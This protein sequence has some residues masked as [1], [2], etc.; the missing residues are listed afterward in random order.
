MA[1]TS[2]PQCPRHSREGGNPVGVLPLNKVCNRRRNLSIL[3]PGL[4]VNRVLYLS[5]LSTL[6]RPAQ[7]HG[8][9]PATIEQGAH[10]FEKLV[11]GPIDHIYGWA[12]SYK[13]CLW[14]LRIRR[15]CNQRTHSRRDR[16]RGG[17]QW[18]GRGV[19]GHCAICCASPSNFLVLATRDFNRWD[20]ERQR[21]IPRRHC[22][23]QHRRGVA[24]FSRVWYLSPPAIHTTL[25]HRTMPDYDLSRLSPRA[26]EHL[27]QA[28]AVKVLGPG[29]VVFGDGPDGGREATFE[30]SVPYPTPDNPWNGYGVV[31]AKYHERSGDVQQDGK[32]A[33][34]Q[35]KKELRKYTDPDSQLRK[36]EYLIY[37]TNVV[38]TPARRRG[39]KDRVTA[40]LDDF[41]K[42]T[43]LRDYAVWDYDQLR[44][45]LDAYE[46][47][48]H[49]YA[50]YITSG[51][52]LAALI[53][54]LGPE[55]MGLYNTL[56][57]FL[58]K[59]LLSDECV[60]LAQAGHDTEDRI[61]L[62]TVFVDLPMQIDPT[63]LDEPFW[64][65][66]DSDDDNEIADCE[67]YTEGF[68]KHILTVASERL[69]PIS[70]G[71]SAISHSFDWTNFRE[72]RGRFVLIGGPGQGKT[73]LTQFLCQIFR[74][75]IISG[76]SSDTISLEVQEALDIIRK[77]CEME[78]INPVVVPRFPFKVVLNDFAKAL[79]SDLDPAVNSLFTYLARQ[80]STR[81]GNGVSASALRRFL[82]IYPSLV[83]FDGLDEVPASSNRDEVLDAIRDFWVEA[84]NTHADVLA[85]ATSRPQGYNDDFSPSHYNHRQLAEL[86]K[87]LGWHFAQRL[88][89]VRYRTDEDRKQKVLERLQRAFL[90][91]STSRLMRSPLQ[92]TMMTALVDRFGQPP[93]ARWN[94]FRSY[95][96]VI[97]LRE[98]ER[99]IPTSNILLDYQPDIKAIHNQVGAI[100]QIDSEQT[101]KTDAKLSRERFI[102]LVQ[103]R[104]AAEGHEGKLL[105]ELSQQIVVAASQRL[106]FLV[107]VEE[108]QIGFEIRS[109]QEFMAAESLMD[110]SDQEIRERLN[111][112]APIPFWR[113]VFLFAAGKCFAE[114]QELRETV[115]AICGAFNELE[116]DALAG[117]YLV[118]SDLAMALLEEGSARRQPR[119]ENMLARI[120]IR[121]LDSGASHL[122][123]KLGDV[124]ESRLEDIYHPELELRLAGSQLTR[125][126]GAWDCLI[127]LISAQVPWAVQ[128][129]Q[130]YWPSEQSDRL[131]ILQNLA[132]PTRN[133]WIMD[134][135]LTLLPAISAEQASAILGP[136]TR[137][138]WSE[139]H[140]LEADL[141]NAI[142]IAQSRMG[143]LDRLVRVLNSGV[144]YGPIMRVSRN[145]NDV[146]Y[147]LAEVEQWHPSWRIYKYGTHFLEAPSKESLAETLRSIGTVVQSTGY[148]PTTFREV[149]MPWPVLACLN[150][151]SSGE[152]L[153][154]LADRS[155]VGELGDV[156]DWTAA[157]KRW[158]EQGITRNDLLSMSDNRLPFDGKMKDR[159]F[160]TAIQ[161]LAAFIGGVTLK[162]D[163]SAVV[164]LFSKLRQGATR[165]FVAKTINFAMLAHQFDAETSQ[166]KALPPIDLRTLEAI[167]R[168]VPSGSPVSLD[169]VVR[170]IGESLEDVSKFF[171]MIKDKDFRFNMNR[172]SGRP[173]IE[174]VR[175]LR[176]AYDNIDGD[177]ALL[178][179]LAVVAENGYLA[180]QYVEIK[181]PAELRTRE[182]KLAA[183]II[184]LSQESWQENRIEQLVASA[185]RIGGLSSDDVNRIV[186]TLMQSKPVGEHGERFVVALKE[187]LPSEEYAAHKRYVDLLENILRR[188]TSRFGVAEERSR[189]ALPEGIM[190]L[191]KR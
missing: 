169:V 17:C 9:L 1:G 130:K 60:N 48:R 44:T 21:A 30:R 88:A 176:R 159:G 135:V 99:N 15:S 80:V 89:A 64:N 90:D 40:V 174:S 110:G 51:D 43:G 39:S 115:N 181:N 179:V 69:D 141:G 100:L 61:P 78:R 33:V 25:E 122:H 111:E 59:E 144:S 92:I 124:Y 22:S 117:M 157:E 79:A 150:A 152:E 82:G 38:L 106:V 138:Q 139:G 134:K 149:D 188:R 160:P 65:D 119:F 146:V 76:K 184:Q 182:E 114:R 3:L 31:Q 180:N 87:G 164:N 12:P 81:T 56:V 170:L 46:D 7:G 120:A 71:A 143:R 95:Y 103:A 45:Y 19:G 6:R 165:T 70:L 11:G 97:Y 178:P 137:R 24:F 2:Q 163:V 155:L 37:A 53:S 101:G 118:G 18:L 127:R 132:E 142:S 93:Q 102:S 94:L 189:F 23:R 41:K 131:F 154:D 116:G 49:A 190:E 77:H 172:T 129:A 34:E 26:F 121:A 67:N 29:V 68:I 57:M 191:L 153:F 85:V 151:C 50:A 86:S 145:D 156:E 72:S 107:E 74:A 14:L 183:F 73:T 171:D 63:E 166:E 83:I 133:A 168:D 54:T 123:L 140:T 5:I 112:I 113:N 36:P 91:A 16:D 35:L 187:L 158:I 98:V 66:P 125:T 28:L 75:S 173:I 186:S 161:P 47:V 128:L 167:Y 105:D 109:L 58:E 27:V 55:P 108:E 42:T 62:A 104:L 20:S 52:V 175:M 147:D 148:A 136:E 126:I 13:R 32:W 84:S 4:R 96:D 177:S 162:R 10:R 8:L 185:E